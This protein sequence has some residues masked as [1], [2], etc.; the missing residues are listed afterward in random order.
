MSRTPTRADDDT[1]MD[2]ALALARRAAASG[3]VPVGAVLVMDGAIAGRGMNRPVTAADPTAHAEILAL[4]QAARRLAN[5]RLTGATLY[6]T[7]EPCLMC[8]GALV[9]ARVDRLV[10][11]ALDPKVGTLALVKRLAA[12]GALN[13]RFTAR[14]GVRGAA[15]RALLV[16][17]FRGRRGR[18]S[19]T[20]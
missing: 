5:Y 16:D 11:G 7:L 6:V 8:A 4:R 13:H 2:A 17:Y 14:T 9:H 15:C 19:K 3:E 18:P 1:F 10:I 12:R 20:P